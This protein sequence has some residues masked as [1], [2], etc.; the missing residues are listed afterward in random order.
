MA[1]EDKILQKKKAL[2]N[3]MEISHGIVS[4]AC[5]MVGCSRQTYYDY[6]R[7]DEAFQL[8]CAETTEVALDYVESK[9][10]DLIDGVQVL[11]NGKDGLEEVYQRPPDNTSIIFYLKTKGKKRGYIERFE[12]STELK[13]PTGETLKIESVKTMTPEG[14]DEALQTILSTS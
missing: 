11:R 8:S 12:Q 1:K 10:F 13:N 6:C 4:T 7:E 3:A 5:I 2:I 9:L 14:V